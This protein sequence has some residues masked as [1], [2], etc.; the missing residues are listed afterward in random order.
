MAQK[1]I[2]KKKG[3]EN[4]HV[5]IETERK[6]REIE[7]KSVGPTAATLEKQ[8]WDMLGEMTK[9]TN[10]DQLLLQMK[11]YMVRLEITP[12]STQC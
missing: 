7:L 9:V 5:K 4:K 8:A 11:K 1:W 12:R 10:V 2:T 6:P 3:E